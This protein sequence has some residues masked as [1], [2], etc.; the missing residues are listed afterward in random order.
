VA[1]AR[2]IG[3]PL[4]WLGMELP[5]AFTDARGQRQPGLVL[6]DVQVVDLPNAP[7]SVLL[8]YGARDDPDRWPYVVLRQMPRAQ[9]EEAQ[10]QANIR[11][12]GEI[13]GVQQ[14]PVQV[15]GGQGTLYRIQPP[16]PSG[17]GSGSGRGGSAPQGGQGNAPALPP[18]VMVQITAGDALAELLT[19]PVV[20]QDGR[21]GNPFLDQTQISALAGALA[22]LN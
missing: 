6:M 8:L 13:P 9:F 11:P 2:N 4:F 3:F 22:R 5:R 16:Q 1:R 20:T 21:Q 17:G 7:R 14:Q 12:I 10:R 18:L 15:P 19:P